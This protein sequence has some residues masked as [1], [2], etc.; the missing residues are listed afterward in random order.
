MSPIAST[1]APAPPVKADFPFAHG[2]DERSSPTPRGRQH[3]SDDPVTRRCNEQAETAKISAQ[4]IGT[5]EEA[6][7]KSSIVYTTDPTQ[8]WLNG[9]E[10]FL[11]MLRGMDKLKGQLKDTDAKTS[12]RLLFDFS[13]VNKSLGR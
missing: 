10:M 7:V 11:K 3:T 6:I 1:R 12:Q 13:F 8:N 5:P 2:G 9:Q 4:W